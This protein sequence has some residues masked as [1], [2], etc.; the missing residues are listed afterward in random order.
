MPRGIFKERNNDWVTILSHRGKD[1]PENETKQIPK[2]ILMRELIIF[3][4]KS[5]LVAG[6]RVRE[7]VWIIKKAK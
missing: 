6:N 2:D 7:S 5:F 1:E 3:S 4:H